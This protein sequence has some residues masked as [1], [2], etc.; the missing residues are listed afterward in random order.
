MR[1]KLFSFFLASVLLMSMVSST[2]LASGNDSGSDLDNAFPV[3]TAAELIAA[4]E[5]PLIPVIEII[6]YIELP[7]NETLIVGAGKTLIVRSVTDG[8][9]SLYGDYASVEVSAGATL[10]NEGG[11]I[12]DRLHMIL[13]EG[14][15][16]NYGDLFSTVV[17]VRGGTF[18]N[19]AAGTIHEQNIIFLQNATMTNSGRI[20]CNVYRISDGPSSVTGV[21]ESQ[22]GTCDM[23]VD[24]DGLDYQPLSLP[25]NITQTISIPGDGSTLI[26][27]SSDELFF[28]HGYSFELS[29]DQ[30]FV[31]LW[32]SDFFPLVIVMD[33][34]F[35]MLDASES[36]GISFTAVDDGTYY[37]LVCSAFLHARG[38]FT[39]TV[40]ESDYGTPGLIDL[41][42]D[43][44]DPTYV[45][46]GAGWIWDPQTLE[47]SMNGARVESPF[48]LPAD[49]T[50]VL[51][52]GT[53]NFVRPP[54]KG[55][56]LERT[57][58][59]QGDLRITGGGNLTINSELDS[60]IEVDG[61]LRIESTGVISV[62]ASWV[63]IYGRTIDIYGCPG[64]YAR[65]LEAALFGQDGIRITDSFVNADGGYD[66]GIFTLCDPQNPGETIGPVENGD[67]IIE[68]SEVRASCIYEWGRAAIYA[69][70]WLTESDIGI[71]AG[72]RLSE[73]VILGPDGGRIVDSDISL[74]KCQTVTHLTD[75][76]TATDW[77]Q[78]A[79]NVHIFPAYDVLYDGNGGTGTLTDDLN[80]YLKGE[81]VT[82]LDN[83]FTR[84]GYVF[85]HWNT[86]ADG[87]GT[88]Y[89][90]VDTFEIDAGVTFYAQWTPV[91][92]VT[93][94]DWDGNVLSTQTIVSGNPATAPA[95]PTREGYNFTGWSV[96][97]SIVTSNLTVTALY[98]A[99]PTPTPTATPSPTPMPE[100]TATPTP[101]PPGGVPRTGETS[102]PNIPA[103]ILL[104][105]GLAAA[106]V[107]LIRKK[108]GIPEI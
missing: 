59:C 32:R 21:P 3:D 9:V 86:S 17:F 61:H 54:A 23:P 42:L 53:D 7:Y 60:G 65:G 18:T 4:L 73:A 2:L 22:L 108:R 24:L 37:L 1:K 19:A 13:V 95:A 15:M 100:P 75:I 72:I 34:S 40:F 58:D 105:T 104:G 80:F 78:A 87:S 56:D 47:L 27:P 70:D 94:E 38:E 103:L 41:T 67:I 45:G 68:N 101:T 84:T 30:T 96:A 25:I 107:L 43:P 76:T 69:G 50:I 98:E 8:G 51:A 92:T 97:F 74:K 85:D 62:A 29:E 90:P 44:T 48:L 33:S 11:I 36:G 5:D 83:A 14:T 16:T 20:L 28:A 64:L 82:V 93:F 12:I 81:T 55:L 71:H 52:D 79:K 88:T 35:N 91:Y 66:F 46:S 26:G 10:I 57:I 49:S 89:D 102:S 99:L 6:G 39:L 77:T 63:A 31:G 106:F